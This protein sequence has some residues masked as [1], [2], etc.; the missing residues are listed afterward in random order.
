MLCFKANDH[1]KFLK[2]LT[3]SDNKKIFE[4]E[5]EYARMGVP[6]PQW[7]ASELNKDYALCDTY[8]KVLHFPATASEFVIKG[9]AGFRSK[10]RLPVL[11][12]LHHNG[13]SI[14][15]CSQ[16]LTGLNARSVEDEQLFH[17][18]MDTNKANFVYVVDTRPK[19][20]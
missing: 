19:V 4:L 5:S 8:P 14:C 1:L 11:S 16:P 6:S 7:A 15:R 2:S 13:A 10:G 17:H 18:I 20:R 3:L 12:Y 9:S